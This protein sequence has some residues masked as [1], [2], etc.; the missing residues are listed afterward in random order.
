MRSPNGKHAAAG[1]NG[2]DDRCGK[3]LWFLQSLAPAAQSWSMLGPRGFPV[4]ILGFPSGARVLS[5][6]LS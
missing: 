5:P 1:G 2:R 3:Q 6:T 4:L